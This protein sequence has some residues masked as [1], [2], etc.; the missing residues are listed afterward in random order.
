L[1]RSA[2]AG[3]HFVLAVEHRARPTAASSLDWHLDG[4]QD[5]WIESKWVIPGQ[6]K[7]AA[8]IAAA[9]QTKIRPQVKRFN[10]DGFDRIR[11]PCA[12]A[13]DE[14]ANQKKCGGRKEDGM[15]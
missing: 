11:K 2:T 9:K 15:E 12:I 4:R 10:K 3:A 1:R 7:S 13:V 6:T 5:H 14:P 8:G